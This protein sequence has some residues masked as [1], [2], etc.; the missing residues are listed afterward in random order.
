M[1]TRHFLSRTSPL[2]PLVVDRILPAKGSGPLELG[3]QWLMVPTRQSG[4]RL[5]ETLA[6]EWRH[7]GG[8][9]LLSLEVH[10]PAFLMQQTGPGELPSAHAFDWVHTWEEVLLEQNPGALPALFPSM[11]ETWTPDAARETG[12]RLQ[13]VR[14]DLLDG[15]LDFQKAC[16]RIS[17]PSEKERWQEL[18]TLEELYRQKLFARGWMDPVDAKATALQNF[19]PGPEITSI[20]LAGVPDPSPAVIERL[21]RLEQER[22]DLQIEVWIHAPASEADLF[23]DWG[24]PLE[25]WRDQELGRGDEPDGWIELVSDSR[26]LCKRVTDLL[27]TQPPLPDI[28]FGLVDET[29]SL[30]L[31]QQMEEVDRKLY[32]PNPCS[33]ADLEWVRI[34]TS[35]QEHR[36]HQDPE[37]LRALMRFATLY[38]TKEGPSTEDVLT[39]WDRY[40]SESFPTSADSVTSS[41]KDPVLLPVWNQVQKWL[42]ATTP[43]LVLE[44]LREHMQ[45]KTLNPQRPAD[46]YLL[47]QLSSLADVLQEAARREQQGNGPS[48]SLLL[49]VLK[50]QSVDPLRIEQAITAEGWLELSYHPSPY[51]L[52]LGFQEGVVPP[53]LK[54]DPFL[55]NGMREEL[56]LKSDRDWI[57]RDAFLFHSLLTSRPLGQVR[58][59]VAKRDMQGNPQLPSRFLFS[60]PRDTMLKRARQLFREPPAPESRPAPSPGVEFD[61]NRVR[62]DIPTSVS[63]SAINQYLTCPTRFFLRH[64]LGSHRVDD[65]AHYPDAAAFGQLVHK[66]LEELVRTGCDSESEWT[67]GTDTLLNQEMARRFA[68]PNGMPS[69]VFQR[70]ARSR[71]LAAG[72]IHR[73]LRSQGWQTIAVEKKLERTCNGMRITGT[74]DRV[75]I[76]PEWGV[77][78]MDMKTSDTAQRP[79]SVH[80]GPAREGRESIHVEV[81]GRTR[82]WTNLQLPLYRWLIQ[83]SDLPIPGGSPLQVAYLNLP[84]AK[85]DTRLDIWKEE[86]QLTQA[87]SHCL[88]AVIEL[89]Q[90]EVWH[91]T[92]EKLLYD[93]FAPFLQNGSDWIPLREP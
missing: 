15:G 91:P 59:L 4:R 32:L 23:D 44:A 69:V 2:L 74:I 19:Q 92:T 9:A 40:A 38:N 65:T 49:R 1:P 68:E 51:V 35:L 85:T 86:S 39:A 34:L 64:V 41:L 13:R 5:R 57:S 24:R 46:R 62:S 17:S 79:A 73:D 8:T 7:R 84:K 77:L 53:P 90:Q 72:R 16:E 93:D 20:V 58:T 54:P 11:E 37:S 67:A 75:D 6:L 45:E 43:A 66:V 42:H 27:R 61:L 71:I 31:Q 83:E 10:P 52:L 14:N 63:V 80:L 18:A 76:H 50:E 21:K 82:Q 47:R 12:Q 78:L 25:S 30:P 28:A 48:L 88:E 89:I 29:L 87:A 60:C 3:H 55:P 26:A 33:L 36:Q 81:K 56:G 70:S 22:P